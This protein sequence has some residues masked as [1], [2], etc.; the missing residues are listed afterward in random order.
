MV[1]FYAMTLTQLWFAIP[2]S[3]SVAGSWQM[4][5]F[6]GTLYSVADPLPIFLSSVYC[7]SR[8]PKIPKLR[9][10][11]FTK[12]E[13]AN[14]IRNGNRPVFLFSD[15]Y[16]LWSNILYLYRRIGLSKLTLCCVFHVWVNSSRLRR[17]IAYYVVKYTLH[18]YIS[19]LGATCKGWA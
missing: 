6:T 19:L 11:S 15:N 1:V 14:V 16:G 2:R 8:T 18:I 10:L 7:L 3:A 9:N 17:W 5:W 12:P 4:T 13:N